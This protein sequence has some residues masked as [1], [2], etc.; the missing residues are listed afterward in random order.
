MPLAVPQIVPRAEDYIGQHPDVV[1]SVTFPVGFYRVIQNGTLVKRIPVQIFDP[2]ISANDAH[3][4]LRAKFYLRV[5]FSPDDRMNPELGQDDD[6]L[7]YMVSCCSYSV[8]IS[9]C[10][11]CFRLGTPAG[12]RSDGAHHCQ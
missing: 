8:R 6:P 9:C 5:L 11:I 2:K 1:V 3:L 4:R 10:N 7:R 12:I